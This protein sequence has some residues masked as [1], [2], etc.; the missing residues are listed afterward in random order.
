A[1]SVGILVGVTMRFGVLAGIASETCR[2]VFGYQIYSSDPSS[3]A[4]YPTLIAI[5][6]A[7]A[8]AWW[9]T[10]TSLAGRSLFG[11]AAPAKA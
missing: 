11:E 10:K 3:W 1:I 8:L 6:L 7:V 5:G 2:R 9:A 4:F